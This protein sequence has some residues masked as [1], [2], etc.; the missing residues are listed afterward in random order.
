MTPV[1]PQQS[2]ERQPCSAYLREG[3]IRRNGFIQTAPCWMSMGCPTCGAPSK[4][5][6]HCL[7]DELPEHWIDERGYPAFKPTRTTHSEAKTHG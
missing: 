7:R 3:G 2:A 1:P 6:P 5:I 4:A